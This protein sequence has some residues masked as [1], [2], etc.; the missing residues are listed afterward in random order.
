[1]S[2]QK[3]G[4]G[5]QEIGCGAGKISGLLPFVFLPCDFFAVPAASSPEVTEEEVEDDDFL[6]IFLVSFFFFRLPPK[7][8][9]L[10]L[11]WESLLGRVVVGMCT[12]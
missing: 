7:L 2:P 8:A 6:L 1:M 12:G 5:Q 9:A 11:Q 3:I 10:L 4:R